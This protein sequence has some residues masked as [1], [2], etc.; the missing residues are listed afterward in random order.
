MSVV[1]FFGGF[2]AG[3]TAAVVVA[4]CWME[5]DQAAHFDRILEQIR[6]LGPGA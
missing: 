2:L 6:S 3:A 5:R 1:C 4:A